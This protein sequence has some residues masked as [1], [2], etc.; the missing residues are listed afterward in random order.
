MLHKEVSPGRTQMTSCRRR[1]MSVYCETLESRRLMSATDGSILLFADDALSVAPGVPAVQGA[2]P[3]L[4]L[5]ERRQLLE[6]W[7]GP[8]L[9]ELSALLNAGD[10]SGFDQ[11]LLDYIVGRQNPRYYFKP[12]DI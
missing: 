9:V 12:Q 7:G 11:L 1:V 10:N 5:T 3:S 8:N 4:S 2:E 6:A